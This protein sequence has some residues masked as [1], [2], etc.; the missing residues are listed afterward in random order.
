MHR[1]STHHATTSWDGILDA[2]DRHRR[3]SG[4]GEVLAGR[5]ELVDILDRGGSGVVWRAWDHEYRCH[6]AAKILR[7]SDDDAIIR[8][9]QESTR[10]IDHPHITVPRTRI[11]VDDT[12]LFTMDLIGGGSVA[13]LLRDFG[14]LPEGWITELA[15]QATDAL[16][17]VHAAGY[18]HRDVKPANLLLQTTGS[19]RPHLRLSDFGS[20]GRLDG[21][22]LTRTAAVIGTDGYLSPEAARGAGPAPG[23]DI[24]AL[25]V[26]LHEMVTGTPPDQSTPSPAPRPVTVELAALIATMI[27]DN[28]ADRPHSADDVTDLI[29]D[30]PAA[31]DLDFHA[32][33]ANPIEIYDQ[34]PP[35]PAGPTATEPMI[36]HA[37]PRD[38]VGR[39]PRAVPGHG[40]ALG[41]AARRDAPVRRESHPSSVATKLRNLASSPHAP[42]AALAVGGL[43]LIVLAVLLA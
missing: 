8:F 22:R 35:L 7:Q 5:F 36:E 30:L 23:Q 41:P 2:D 42:A 32:D 6:V 24:Y 11:A 31:G 26:T 34:L 17:A 43:V 40:R 28:P 37:L 10:I 15:H 39:T 38:G 12:I 4:V 14:P 16:A 3:R 29:A 33:P 18:A 27:A 1:V 21:P 25:G 13:T 19:G 20:A 9:V